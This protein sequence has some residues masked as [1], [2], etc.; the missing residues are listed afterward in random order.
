MS[1]ITSTIFIGHADQYHSGIHPTHLIMLSENSRPSFKVY[2]IINL[3]HE[4]TVIPTAENMMDDLLSLVSAHVIKAMP[5]T[6]SLK[7]RKNKTFYEIFDDIERNELY[8]LSKNILKKINVKVVINLLE[9]SH[10]LNELD[11]LKDYDID[12]EVTTTK[13][14]REF[15]V[16]SQKTEIKEL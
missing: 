16:W 9:E 3:K 10:L 7:L 8:K 14:K 1:T 11:R 5:K 2:N 13:L 15:S 4:I 12:Y 6:V